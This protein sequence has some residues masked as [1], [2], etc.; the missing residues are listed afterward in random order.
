MQLEAINRRATTISQPPVLA[1]LQVFTGKSF[2]LTCGGMEEYY[3]TNN[4]AQA[5]RKEV[6]YEIL[7]CFEIVEWKFSI[8]PIQFFETGTT[9]FSLLLQCVKMMIHVVIYT[10]IVTLAAYNFQ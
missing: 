5:S 8:F 10:Y 6:Y 2:R 4:A 1:L 9:L 3:Y 7:L